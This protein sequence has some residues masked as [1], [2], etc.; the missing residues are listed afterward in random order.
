M[1]E[2]L[3]KLEIS[4]KRPLDKQIIVGLTNNKMIALNSAFDKKLEI[5]VRKHL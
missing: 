2:S 1:G 5:T 4:P 3:I